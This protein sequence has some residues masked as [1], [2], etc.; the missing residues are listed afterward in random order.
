[1]YRDYY[2]PNITEIESLEHLKHAGKI[3]RNSPPPFSILEDQL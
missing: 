3:P 2:Y 1:M